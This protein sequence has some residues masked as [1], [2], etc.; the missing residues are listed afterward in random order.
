MSWG[1]IVV[2]GAGLIVSSISAAK[3]RETAEGQYEESLAFQKE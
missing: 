1:A 2:G 3:N